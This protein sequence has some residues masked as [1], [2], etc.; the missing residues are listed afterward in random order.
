[1]MVDVI[2][3]STVNFTITP[4]NDCPV[5]TGTTYT[6]MEGATLNKSELEGFLRFDFD[7]DGDPFTVIKVTDPLHAT[8]LH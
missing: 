7:V 3:I 2:Q 6:V 8:L 5:A 1:M 4:V